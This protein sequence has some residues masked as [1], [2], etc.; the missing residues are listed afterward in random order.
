MLAAIK[1]E[2]ALSFEEDY[3]RKELLTLYFGGG[4][5][6]VLSIDELSG[7]MTA[8]KQYYGFSTD[9]EITLEANPDAL[10]DDYLEG[11][12]RLGFNRLSIGIQSFF[13]DDLRWMNR[14]HSSAEALRSVEK[15]R[16]HGFHNIN[17]DIMYGLPKMTLAR[18]QANL[19]QALALDVPH[20][21]AYH[22]I[23]E[24]RSV[25]G[26]R[27]G[28]GE[29]FSVSEEQSIEQFNTL[30]D[31]TEKEDYEHYEISNFARQGFRSQHNVAHWQLNPYVGIGPAAHSFDGKSRRW[32][33]NNNSKY[34]AAIEN[35]TKCFERETLTS[36]EQYNEYVLVSLRA[37]WGVDINHIR[38]NFDDDYASYFLKQ[39][40]AY[41]HNGYMNEQSGVFTLSRKGKMAAD[42]IVSDLFCFFKKK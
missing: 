9:T 27:Q 18:W 25:F 11:L 24:D 19:T 28:R 37:A 12:C 33:I 7:L 22:L 26:K 30:L 6:S 1:K 17:I 31:M 42:R 14:S 40:A 20:L 41:L 10:N 15:A 3:G 8:I 13:D 29:V 4:T 36:D 21:S 2:I 35:S 5:P 39:A 32:N 23:I 34:I 16:K 38:A